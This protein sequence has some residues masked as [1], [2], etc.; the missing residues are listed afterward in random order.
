MP[1]HMIFQSIQIQLLLPAQTLWYNNH[2]Q[3]MHPGESR[4]AVAIS[5]DNI[6]TL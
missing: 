2:I 3:A 5:G 4:V 6:T 1:F